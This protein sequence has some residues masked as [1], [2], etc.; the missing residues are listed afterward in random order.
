MLI[1]LEYP[2][3]FTIYEISNNCANVFEIA[4]QLTGTWGIEAKNPTHRAD[5]FGVPTDFS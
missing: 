2:A 1:V 4:G 5:R 3:A